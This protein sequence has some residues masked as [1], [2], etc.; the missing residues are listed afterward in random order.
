MSVHSTHC[1]VRHGCK[2]GFG[3]D[4][5]CPVVFG[6]EVQEY[7]CESCTTEEHIMLRGVHHWEGANL[8]PELEQLVQDSK[9][10]YFLPL[11]VLQ[12]LMEKYD[13]QVFHA[14]GGGKMLMLDRAGKRHRQR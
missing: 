5:D 11:S 4:D 1:C 10:E 13:V 3:N 12:D 2:Y 6:P 14:H 9:E 8:P 7:P